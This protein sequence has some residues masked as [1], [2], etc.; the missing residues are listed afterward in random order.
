MAA[1]GK[2]LIRLSDVYKSF[3]AL[4]VLGGISFDVAKGEVM[5]IIG[6]SGSGKSTLLRCIN[7]LVPIDRGS[8]LVEG[9]EVNDPSSTSSRCGA[10][11]AWCSSSTTCSRTAP[12]SRTS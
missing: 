7:A 12:R 8:I 6:P 1:T 5:C 4:V 2:L 10:R 11:S 3:G 9:Q